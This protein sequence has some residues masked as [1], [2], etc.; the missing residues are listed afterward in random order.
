[1]KPN[2]LSVLL[3]VVSLIGASSAIAQ[4]QSRGT[5]KGHNMPAF[6]EIDVNADG[7]IVADEFYQARGKRMAERAASG[8]KMR[9]AANAPSF[10]D[11]DT[12]GDGK[13]S[14]DEFSAHQAEHQRK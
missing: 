10:E 6:S 9:N 12:D 5:G 11:I 8:G 3:F 1:M 4:D 14:P 13:V 7:N 2:T